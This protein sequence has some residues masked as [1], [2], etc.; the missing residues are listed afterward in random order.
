MQLMP[1][2]SSGEFT[3]PIVTSLEEFSVF[4]PR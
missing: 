4:L 3:A 2:K 1:Q